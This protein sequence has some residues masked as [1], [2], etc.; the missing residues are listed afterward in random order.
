LNEP[1]VEGAR[2]RFKAALGVPARW[3]ATADEIARL[4]TGRLATGR[5]TPLAR[6]RQGTPI[7][8]AEGMPFHPYATLAAKAARASNRAC[9]RS[10]TGSAATALADEVDTAP[11]RRAC[12]RE[13]GGIVD[14][15]HDA[16]RHLL[17]DQRPT[18]AQQR[19]DI[20]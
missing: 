2:K 3:E 20:R 19:P 8:L 6:F 1:L 7:R 16:L 17:P 18:E 11:G 10:S 12:P 9:A 13:G 15:E 14:I 4:G 5:F